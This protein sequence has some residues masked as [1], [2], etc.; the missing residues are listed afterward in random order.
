MSI[1]F[2]D[3]VIDQSGVGFQADALAPAFSMSTRSAC[4]KITAS[5][6]KRVKKIILR[7]I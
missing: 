7:F 5:R 2:I 4:T 3:G 1:Q 6:H